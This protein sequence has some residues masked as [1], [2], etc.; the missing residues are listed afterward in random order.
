MKQFW[1]ILLSAVL[2]VSLIPCAG[3]ED[4]QDFTIDEQMVFSDMSRSYLQGYQPSTSY[5]RLNLV[6]PIRSEHAVGSINAELIPAQ[7][8]IAPFKLQN[9][10][11][12]A[13]SVEDGLWAVRFSLELFSDR[14]NGDYPCT[15]RVSGADSSSRELSTDFEMSSISGT[16]GPAHS[17]PSS[18]SRTAAPGSLPAATGPCPCSSPTPVP[19]WA[20][21][22]CL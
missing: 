12:R 22:T 2:L 5:N 10:G 17:F 14:R 4:S 21:R 20:F 3:A 19:A 15:V 8:S 1:A 13:Q 11:V 6:I 16:A 9:M 18:R 7:E